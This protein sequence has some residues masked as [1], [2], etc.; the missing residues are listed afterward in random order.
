MAV[1][2]D[3][4]FMGIDVG[5]FGD[6]SHVKLSAILQDP[7]AEAARVR[8]AAQAAGL[9]VADVFL[10]PS[11]D[12][13]EM[14]PN[15]PDPIV[16]KASFELYR[17]TI[18]FACA[19][20]APGVTLLP[21]VCFAADTVEDAITRAAEALARRVEL[22]SSFGLGL[23][24]E[25][26]TGSCVE[27]P[28]HFAELLKQT[29]GLGA[30]LD[31]GHYAYGGFTV[32]DLTPLLSRTRHVQVRPCGPGLMQGRLPDNEFDLESFLEDLKSADYSGWI[33]TEFVWMEK[34]S[35]DRVDNTS[36]TARLKRYLTEIG[37]RIGL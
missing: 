28:E 18:E 22:A 4:G 17:K 34:W 29:P 7:V 27:T 9:A 16:R 11:S 3:L 20:G 10:I 26:H 30:T 35:C 31:P 24:V 15:H 23:S 5:V 32:S 25:G 13:E 8:R 33:A 14:A 19:L 36:E 1:A 21:G 2:A 12:L 37:Q 6:D